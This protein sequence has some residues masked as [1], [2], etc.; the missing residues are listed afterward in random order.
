MG[1]LVARRGAIASRKAASGGGGVEVTGVDSFTAG[2]AASRS[3]QYGYRFT[4]T[5]T[6]SLVRLR[7]YVGTAAAF[8]ARLWRDS[9]GVLLVDTTIDTAANEWSGSALFAAVELA[10]SATYT[11]GIYGGGSSFQRYLNG[12]LTYRSAVGFSTCVYGGGSGRPGTTYG[13]PLG[14]AD[15]VYAG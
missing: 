11:V 8:D 6:L 14:Y 5:E 7:A 12:T 3:D 4:P 13:S 9:D 1:L 2:S 10:A 15:I